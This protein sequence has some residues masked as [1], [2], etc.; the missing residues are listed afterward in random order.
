MAALAYNLKKLLN[1]QSKKVQANV[2]ALQKEVSASIVKLTAF[3]FWH[4]TK[5]QFL[6]VV[7]L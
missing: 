7:I 6:P 5:N 2:K 4:N 1:W 3:V